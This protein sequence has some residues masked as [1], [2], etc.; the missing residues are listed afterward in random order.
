M[1]Y[2]LFSK[3]KKDVFSWFGGMISQQFMAETI[4]YAV[5]NAQHNSLTSAWGVI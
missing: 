3:E 2:R 4:T 1:K 5:A